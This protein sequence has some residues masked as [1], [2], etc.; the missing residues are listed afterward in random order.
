MHPW[1]FFAV[2]W[3]SLS[4]GSQ[5]SSRLQQHVGVKRVEEHIQGCLDTRMSPGCSLRNQW[6]T[7]SNYQCGW[8]ACMW[9]RCT[10]EVRNISCYPFPSW[11]EAEASHFLGSA[12]FS[13][14]LTLLAAAPEGAVC[15]RSVQCQGFATPRAPYLLDATEIKLL[16]CLKKYSSC[17]ACSSAFALQIEFLACGG[18]KTP[19]V[20]QSCAGSR[21]TMAALIDFYPLCIF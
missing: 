11:Q 12:P 18:E 21:G 1:W 16:I 17:R 7:K 9:V 20:E 2:L 6:C 8:A 10:R 14:T 13:F 4:P 3:I 15:H 19:C 5:H